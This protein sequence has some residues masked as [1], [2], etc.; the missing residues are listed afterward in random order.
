MGFFKSTAIFL[1]DCVEKLLQRIG[2]Q[3]NR[4]KSKA[5]CLSIFYYVVGRFSGS[6]QARRPEKYVDFQFSLFLPQGAPRGKNKK[7]VT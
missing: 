4:S 2:P 3:T 6:P 5:G 1:F 7:K